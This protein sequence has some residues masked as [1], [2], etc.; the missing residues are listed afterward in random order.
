MWSENTRQKTIVESKAHKMK[1]NC[2]QN[3]AETRIHNCGGRN[4]CDAGA[5]VVLLVK[6]NC[7]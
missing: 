1:C 4:G 3:S 5:M 6:V 7:Q 2:V